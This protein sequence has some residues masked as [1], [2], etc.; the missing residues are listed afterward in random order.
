MAFTRLS[1]CRA[2]G[3][4]ACVAALSVPIGAAT[5]QDND[6]VVAR[7]NGVDI[8]ES[9]LAFAEEEI[10]GN[11]PNMP[12][13]QKRDYLINYLIDVI[14]LSQAAEQQ[15]L[16]DRPD[17]KHRL[18]FD[19][20]RL[21]MEALLQDTGHAALS[22]QAEHEVYDE[23]IKQVKNEEE[24][25]ARHILVATEDEAKAI[26]CRHDLV[27]TLPSTHTAERVPPVCPAR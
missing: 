13:E 10:G 20:N 27:C 21:L 4:L 1:L 12:P 24:V 14:V 7:A 16:P 19:R 18:T 22:D 2:L 25:H 3:A 11:I 26:E 17:V 8:H 9:D 15:K 5:A 23:A 6:P